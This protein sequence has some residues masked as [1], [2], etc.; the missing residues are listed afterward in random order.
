FFLVI[1]ALAGVISQG[2][3]SA[4]SFFKGWVG[5]TAVTSMTA[6]L[7]AFVMLIAMALIRTGA[8]GRA[9]SATAMML[10]IGLWPALGILLL[11]WTFKKLFKTHSP[12]TLRGMQAMAG[13]PYAVAGAVTSGGL[14]TK[15]L[16]DD[17]RKK[18]TGAAMNTAKGRL[19]GSK[20][21]AN[22]KS[23]AAG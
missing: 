13:N 10:S 3:G 19:L 8:A 23:A 21:A 16:L 4:A 20:D 7:F 5:Y 9:G 1:A 11:N 2:L 15:N 12:F 14:L 18:I 17:G 6:L 22:S